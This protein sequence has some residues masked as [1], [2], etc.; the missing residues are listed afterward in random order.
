MIHFMFKTA[1][2][3]LALKRSLQLSIKNAPILL[4]ILV[5][6]SSV[7]APAPAR[8]HETVET[9]LYEAD[10]IKP[11]D[12]EDILLKNAPLDDDGA[13]TNREICSIRPALGLG[14]AGSLYGVTHVE[15]LSSTVRNL[16]SRL[17]GEQ[18]GLKL[19]PNKPEPP[20]AT[21]N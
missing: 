9:E 8:A 20:C 5:V 7:I 21:V 4:I 14:I 10:W 18:S 12:N 6:L 17:K 2:E 15:S 16:L 19:S 13:Q 1:F 3:Q 11:S